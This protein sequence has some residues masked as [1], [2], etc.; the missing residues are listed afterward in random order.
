M[1]PTVNLE[2]IS[3]KQTTRFIP[4]EYFELKTMIHDR[5]LD[6]VDL[7]LIES[8]DKDI[9]G[10]QIKAVVERI[11]REEGIKVPLNSS[12]RERLFTEIQDEVL[13]LGPLEPFLQ[14]SKISDI[15]VN[16]YGQIY[17]EKFG[18][19]ELTDSRFKDDAHLMKIIDRIVSAMGLLLW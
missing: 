2:I 19:L 7:S 10:S 8:Q 18:K 11:L 6:L 17:V 16:A 14:D 12:E 13:G 9:L 5:L 3:Q 1:S 4:E 15:L